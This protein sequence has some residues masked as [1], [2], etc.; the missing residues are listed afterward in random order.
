MAQALRNVGQ[1][2]LAAPVEGLCSSLTSTG[3]PRVHDAVR[4]L[5]EFA[6]AQPQ[7]PTLPVSEAD[8]GTFYQSRVVRLAQGR[9]TS[10]LVD[11]A[12]RDLQTQARNAFDFTK[13]RYSELQQQQQL[14]QK[15][16]D[17]RR[18]LAEQ[19]A[20]MA[21]IMSGVGAIFGWVAVQGIK[22]LIDAIT[23]NLNNAQQQ[24]AQLASQVNAMGH[25]INVVSTSQDHLSSLFGLS[26]SMALF[27]ADMTTQANT[28][29]D[30]WVVLKPMKELEIG[31]Y[32]TTWD[33]VVKSFSTWDGVV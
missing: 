15:I 12:L 26:A 14:M 18:D 3:I 20:K 16:V 23:G 30:L 6:R 28:A 10:V 19:Q 21:A 4:S 5:L 9:D 31:L 17:M 33:A 24:Q 13:G 8:R 27:W 22:A 7:V 2:D 32:Q 29:S 25:T 1:N 11:S